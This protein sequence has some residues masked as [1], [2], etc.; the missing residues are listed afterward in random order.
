MEELDDV[1]REVLAVGECL[2]FLAQ[3]T[4]GQ[5]EARLCMGGLSEILAQLADRTDIAGANLDDLVS[6]HPQ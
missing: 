5:N 6:S 4:Q 2:R 1:A 3:T